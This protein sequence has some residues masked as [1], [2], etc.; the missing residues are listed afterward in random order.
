MAANETMSDEIASATIVDALSSLDVKRV[1]WDLGAVF[2]PERVRSAGGYDPLALSVTFQ[3]LYPVLKSRDIAQSILWT[4]VRLTRFP[5]DL[6]REYPPASATRTLEEAGTP[7]PAA[8]P[9]IVAQASAGT[10]P[11]RSLAVLSAAEW[12]T[13][14]RGDVFQAAASTG[15]DVGTLLPPPTLR[16][17]ASTDPAEGV[18]WSDFLPLIAQTSLLLLQRESGCTASRQN[19]PVCSV[20]RRPASGVDAVYAAR[21][22]Q[23]L[24]PRYSRCVACTA[25]ANAQAVALALDLRG[26]KQIVWT[27]KA[28]FGQY[29]TVTPV[30]DFLALFPELREAG[31]Y[32]LF[33]GFLPDEQKQIERTGG[34]ENLAAPGRYSFRES[35]RPW[36]FW[37]TPP[38][39]SNASLSNV[40]PLIATEE[41]IRVV[42][43]RSALTIAGTGE[44][45]LAQDPW[46]KSADPNPYP[47]IATTPAGFR[48]SDLAGSLDNAEKQYN[49]VYRAECLAGA[50]RGLPVPE[51]C[52]RLVPVP[53]PSATRTRQLLVWQ[54]QELTKRAGALAVRVQEF[55]SWV[56]RGAD[57]FLREHPQWQQR[58][59]RASNPGR[60]TCKGFTD[61]GVKKDFF[62]VAASITASHAWK[63]G[64]T[65]PCAIHAN[66]LV[67]PG[68]KRTTVLY[69][70]VTVHK[71]AVSLH[72]T[73]VATCSCAWQ[74]ARCWPL[75]KT[76]AAVVPDAVAVAVTEPPVAPLAPWLVDDVEEP[77][78]APRLVDDVEETV[79]LYAKHL[80]LF[81]LRN[82]QPLP[83]P[84]GSLATQTEESVPQ[85]AAGQSSSDHEWTESLRSDAAAGSARQ[86]PCLTLEMRNSVPLLLLATVLSVQ[87]AS[88]P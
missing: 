54:R 32:Q 80:P 19:K 11:G 87:A 45:P 49:S 70:T 17:V 72:A 7:L 26:R 86:P 2:S 51:W 34:T 85:L 71:A 16:V 66:I 29:Q 27:P 55:E 88:S 10:L 52:D 36:V 73:V 25:A 23:S 3:A 42:P 41:G 8:P 81:L 68:E 63:R 58:S 35:A 60:E 40:Y 48:F 53:E 47:F 5:Y 4:V 6:V 30:P 9:K 28:V 24:Y 74:S 75:I 12:E 64:A 15:S 31:F 37:R 67:L 13:G 38:S 18:V 56:Q 69:R 46:G 21:D 77:P 14:R 22:P 57:A 33:L 83:A 1:F 61:D 39:L 78:V 76:H 79:G 44:L 20:A 59:V 84:L 82:L 62:F 50:Q 65:L 43:G